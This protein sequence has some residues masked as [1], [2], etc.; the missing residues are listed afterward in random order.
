MLTCYDVAKY[1]LSLC[2]DDESGDLI[3]NLKIQKLVYYAQGFSLAIHNKPLFQEK[4]QA[5]MHGP[6]VPD[7]YNKYKK[8][9]NGALPTTDLNIDFDKFSVE[10]KKLLDDVYDVYGQFSAWK[11]R[12]MTHDEMPWKS[13]Y[14]LG[15]SNEISNEVLKEYFLTLTE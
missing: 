15:K 8:Y 13:T 2:N 10:E 12:N 7:L 3:S 14:Q 9:E 5:W 6:V 1:F 4:I 11:L